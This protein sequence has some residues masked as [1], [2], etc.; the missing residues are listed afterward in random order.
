MNRAKQIDTEKRAADI[1]K[2]RELQEEVVDETKKFEHAMAGETT[3]AK[4][5]LP[6]R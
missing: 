1:K 4:D 6:M 2:A 5:S 3:K